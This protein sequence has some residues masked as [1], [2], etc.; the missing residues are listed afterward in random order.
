MIVLFGMVNLF[1]IGLVSAFT[2]L[3]SILRREY[4]MS[5]EI[6]EALGNRRQLPDRG[7]HVGEST[8]VLPQ[9]R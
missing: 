5:G 9:C 4:A 6:Q 3:T 2:D 7:G 8:R 1:F